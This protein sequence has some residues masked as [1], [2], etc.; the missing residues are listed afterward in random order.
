[1][2]NRGKGLKGFK[3]KLRRPNFAETIAVIALF[4]ALGGASY[5]AIKIPKNS[6]GTKQLKKN[7]VTSA[8]VKNRSLLAADF[9]AGQ[10]PAGATGATGLVGPR[11]ATGEQGIPGFPGTP[12]TP[13]IN[14][15]DGLPGSPGPA[16]AT[17]ATGATG[18][19]GATGT[20]GFSAMTG[21]TSL[22][23][24]TQFFAVSGS[25]V[26][27][28]TAT[29]LGMITPAVPVTLK[30]LM[31]VT[32]TAPGTGIT[33]TFV[34]QEDGINVISCTLGGIATACFNTSGGGVINAGS[35]LPMFDTVTGG[36]AAPSEARWGF[37]I[38]S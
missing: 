11:G 18:S 20:G 12:G 6:V 10:L 30:N 4:V 32:D 1:M 7:A 35:T 15:I 17:G 9:K 36:S 23:S 3:S 24:S 37:T 21:R 27:G 22:G 19:T 26:A 2:G 38:G 29:G 8:K 34:I 33:R 14:G 28:A 25:S 31:V 13:G 5:A 16:G